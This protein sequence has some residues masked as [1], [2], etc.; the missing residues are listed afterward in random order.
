[1]AQPGT[2]EITRLLQA[3]REDPEAD[4]DLLSLVYDE[5]RRMAAACMAR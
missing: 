4:L 2:G 5:L 1:M 3:A